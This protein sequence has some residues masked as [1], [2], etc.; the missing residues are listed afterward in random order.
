MA[1]I[2]LSFLFALSSQK[3]FLE[4][5]N[6]I[7]KATT[8]KTTVKR[9]LDETIDESI[10]N[11]DDEAIALRKTYEDGVG[12]NGSIVIEDEETPLRQ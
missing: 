2:I 11:L 6:S 12:V 9:S 8:V 5:S 1:I 10:V 7:R 4:E 3:K